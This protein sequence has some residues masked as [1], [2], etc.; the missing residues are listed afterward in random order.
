MKLDKIQWNELGKV[1]VFIDAANIFYSC[2]GL[3]WHIKYERLQKYFQ[4][5]CRLVDIYF[6][7]A[8]KENNDHDAKLLGVLAGLGFK[9]KVRKQK[10]F[11]NP[12]GTIQIKGNID[13]ELIVDLVK[14]KDQCDTVFLMSGDGDFRY[15]VD[16]L[17]EF[18]KKVFVVSTKYHV[19]KELIDASNG[20]INMRDLKNEW[21][22][23]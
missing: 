6:Y 12:D 23:T 2:R 16:F 7:Y 11:K 3:G 19:A 5:S 21:T 15:A 4:E 9:I 22:F 10:I 17:R 20:Y 18:G 1:L 14:L 8:K 13:G